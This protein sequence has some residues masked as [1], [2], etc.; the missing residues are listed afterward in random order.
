MLPKKYAENLNK[1][2]LKYRSE[3]YLSDNGYYAVTLGSGL[4]LK[5]AEQRVKYA[6]S[7]TNITDAYVR[8]SDKFGSN[9]M[10]K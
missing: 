1:K 8:T 5:K 10:K 7:K 9:L 4:S 3:V 2:K 6:K